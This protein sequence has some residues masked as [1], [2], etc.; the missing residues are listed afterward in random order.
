[1]GSGK[2]SLYIIYKEKHFMKE[3]AYASV[4]KKHKNNIYLLKMNTYHCFQATLKP[5][6]PLHCTGGLIHPVKNTTEY[7]MLCNQLIINLIMPIMPEIL[8]YN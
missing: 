6:F 5:A 8:T 3:I 4:F 2:N 1:M 7:Y